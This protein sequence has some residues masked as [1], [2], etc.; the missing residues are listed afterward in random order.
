MTNQKIKSVIRKLEAVKK[1]LAKDR[2]LFREVES[3]ASELGDQ[4]QEACDDITRA[5]DTLSQQV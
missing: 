4:C 3:E 2:D 1:R 5:I